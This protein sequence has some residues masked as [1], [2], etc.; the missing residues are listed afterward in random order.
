M[1]STRK[2]LTNVNITSRQL[3]S[4]GEK[5]HDDQDDP[6]TVH[7]EKKEKEQNRWQEKEGR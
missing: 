1:K 3:A 6:K 4:L 5:D 2:V 7:L